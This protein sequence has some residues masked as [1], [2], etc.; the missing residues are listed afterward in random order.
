MS[1]IPNPI[2]DVNICN[3]E[4][5]SLVKMLIVPNRNVI[6]LIKIPPIS[7]YFFSAFFKLSLMDFSS[8]V[9]SII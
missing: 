8:F 4:A 2:V 6:A 7:I 5:L 3:G 9:C 1:K